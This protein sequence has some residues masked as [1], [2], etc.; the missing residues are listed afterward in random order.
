MRSL[1]TGAAGFVGLHLVR[2]LTDRGDE[3]IAT[4]VAPMSVGPGATTQALDI[5]DADAVAEALVGVDVVFHVASLVHTKQ[6]HSD[7]V[8]AVN[9]VGTSNVIAAC[10]AAGVKRLVYISSASVVYEGADIVNGDE[11]LP[12]ARTSQAPYADS[13]I[14]AERDVLAANSVP[15]ATCAIRP[16]VVYGPEDG[17][18]LPAIL[19][20]GL[21]GKLRVG[22]GRGNK[23]S[24]FTYISNLTDGTLRAEEKLRESGNPV[25][26][27]AYFVT[28]GEPLGFWE[29]I[30]RVL[31]AIGQPRTKGRI[32]FA[33]AYPIAAIAEAIDTLKGGTLG[34]ENGFTRFAVRYM[35]SDHYFSVDKAR[36]DFGY[37][38]TVS[39][40]E[41][42]RL[43]IQHLRATG[44]IP[45]GPS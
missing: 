36:R 40:D 34:A 3:V 28:N 39:I 27:E 7:T 38:P 9:H 5:T 37:V 16:H 8:W 19:E 18:F 17:R 12:Y 25:G 2:A 6:N 11:T 26:G 45:T 20:R 14:A 32:P 10:R 4:D 43:T 23:L 29:F 1:V 22:V 33:I 15:L 21:A 24:D 30:D 13:K 35:C 42:I 41:G 44:Q 31:E